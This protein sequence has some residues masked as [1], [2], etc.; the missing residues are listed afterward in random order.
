[1]IERKGSK[2]FVLLVIG[3]VI[4]IFGSSL[5]RFGL[6][7]YILDLTGRADIFA[8]L[9]A[10]SSLPQLFSPIGGAIADRV[11]RRNM[12]VGID[13]LN[14]VIV[15]GLMLSIG[16]GYPNV[17]VVGIVM[18]LLGLVN[19]AA[20]PVVQA[21]V[22]SIVPKEKLEEKNGIISGVGALSALMSPVLGG[23]LYGIL[24]I[25]LFAGICLASFF[26][27]GI[28]EMFIK[29]PYTK[30]EIAGSVFR[31]ILGDLKEGFIFIGKQSLI[32]KSMMLA[33]ILNLLLTPFFIVG[34]PIIL[35]V[36][37]ESNDTMYG[38]G[39]G[40]LELATILGALCVGFFIKKVKVNRLYRWLMMMGLLFLPMAYALTPVFLSHGFYPSYLLYLLSLI[41]VVMA[42]TILSI[43]IISTV[44]RGT[45]DKLLGK[46]MATITAVAQCAA[47]IGQIV[48]G[49]LFKEMQTNIFTLCLILGCVLMGLA[50]WMKGL[51][52]NETE[53]I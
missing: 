15:G 41:P 23:L 7:L 34:A 20:Q 17:L 8:I 11:N 51:L 14:C 22:P 13:I 32:R 40:A 26:L 52:M 43:Y 5:L 16:M 21:S 25:E 30:R 10:I 37:M 28:L 39:M 3:Q 38:I 9:F 4:S 53:I 36:T 50:F 49:F 44:Q 19:M 27:A 18:F 24:G 35:R 12:I 29:I 31:T 33:A 6:S 42:L 47:P 1:M 48:Y 46:V 2:D 45:P